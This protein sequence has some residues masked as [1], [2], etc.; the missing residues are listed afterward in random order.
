M[1]LKSCWDGMGP[2]L[3]KACAPSLKTCT[4]PDLGVNCPFPIRPLF[5]LV[6]RQG[7]ARIEYDL[8]AIALALVILVNGAG[9]FSLNRV[10]S[11]ELAAVYRPHQATDGDRRRGPYL[12]CRNL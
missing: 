8:L 7:R 5:E 11:E 3:P 9:A 2:V 12:S 10:V 4:S 6:W 1:E